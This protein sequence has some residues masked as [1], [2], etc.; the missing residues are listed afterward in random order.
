MP[1]NSSKGRLLHEVGGFSGGC[2]ALRAELRAS[3]LDAASA[4]FSETSRKNCAVRFSVSGATSSFTKLF[5]R[6]SSSSTR[7]PKSSKFLMLLS[8]A[9]SSSMCLP[10]SSNLSIAPVPR[11]NRRKEKKTGDLGIIG[12]RCAG[13]K[14][15]NWSFHIGGSGG[16]KNGKTPCAH[17]LAEAT[18]NRGRKS[19]RRAM[20][21]SES[22][23]RAATSAERACDFLSLP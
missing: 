19:A 11:K 14:E 6:S 2:A 16:W 17:F 5:T 12:T 3:I 20:R 9:N 22:T 18:S 13:R 4:S 10:N 23:P 21:W 15:E 8:R 7:L 1:V